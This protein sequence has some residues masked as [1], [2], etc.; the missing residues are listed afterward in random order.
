MISIEEKVVSFEFIIY[1]IHT[2]LIDYGTLISYIILPHW[3]Y[4]VYGRGT[5]SNSRR[6]YLSRMTCC[7]TGGRAWGLDCERCPNQGSSKGLKLRIM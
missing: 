5:C 4:K 3:L 2:S 7:C 6:G 1:I